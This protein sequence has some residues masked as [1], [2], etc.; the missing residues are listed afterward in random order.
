MVEIASVYE[1]RNHGTCRF[2]LRIRPNHYPL[3]SKTKHDEKD[4]KTRLFFVRRDSIPNGRSLPLQW[5]R[6]ALDLEILAPA[7]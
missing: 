3:L 2:T 5:T 4:W 6:N 7:S 1:L